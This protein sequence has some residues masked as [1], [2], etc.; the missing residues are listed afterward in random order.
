MARADRLRHNR[1]MLL[2][3]A[4]LAEVTLHPTDD[5][6]VYPHAGD[7]AKDAYLRVWGRDGAAV[8]KTA[9][10]SEDLSYSLLR[11]DPA[12]LPDGKLT[13]AV[14]VLTTTGGPSYTADDAKAHP[15]QARAVDGGFAEKG[16]KYDLL[17]RFLPTYDPKSIYGTGAPAF[18]KADAEGRV[19]IDLLKG[20]NDFRAALKNKKPFGIALTSTLDVQANEG[21]MTIYKLY[22]KD[23]PVEAAR[24]RLELSFE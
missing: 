17:E 16:W 12:S 18:P 1:P 11:F 23:A 10:D 22:S 14:L 2:A 8:A 13:K 15:L 7:P 24:P 19:E 4:L 20:P 3:L 21:T 9:G 5:V 6:W